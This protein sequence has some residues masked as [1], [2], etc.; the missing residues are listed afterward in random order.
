MNDRVLITG[1]AGYIGS[2]V[3]KMVA[4]SGFTPVVFDNLSTG[5]REAV[6]FGPFFEGDLLNR[7]HL[8]YVFNEYKP[9][10]VM[11]LAARSQVSE[12]MK[13]PGLYW[14]NNFLGTLNLIETAR[15]FKCKNFVFSS[16]CAVYG[17]NV[18][19]E[20]D[21][22]SVVK[23]VSAYAYSKLAIENLLDSFKEAYG[24]QYVI[25]R[26]FNVAGADPDGQLGEVHIPETHLIPL[27]LQTLGS[28]SNSFTVYGTDYDT[29]DGT[30]VRDYVHVVDIADAHVKGLN[31]LISGK[32]SKIFNL[33]SGNGFSVLEIINAVQRVAGQRIDI[34]IGDRRPGDSASLTS[35][36]RLARSELEWLPKN[37]II[38]VMIRDAWQW[39]N[40][41]KFGF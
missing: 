33:G 6:K 10:A 1:G 16:T 41:S 20:L 25:F 37:S 19:A 36:S 9:I 34:K 39:H 28:N 32:E 2:H 5:W 24:L 13:D 29:R 18:T 14:R 8:N 40:S 12:S 15:D 7:K 3:A 17:E 27:L 38:D 26:Y 11:H 4:H 23:P 22:A 35:N 31:W 21:E 30:C